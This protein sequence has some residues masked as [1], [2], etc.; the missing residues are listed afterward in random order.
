[1]SIRGGGARVSA[2]PACRSENGSAV[3]EL[4]RRSA[5]A[6]SWSGSRADPTEYKVAARALRPIGE[7][8]SV[9][10]RLSGS[11]LH[12]RLDRRKPIQALTCGRVM[13]E[14][15]GSITG[16]EYDKKARELKERQTEIA[17]RIEQHQKGED[18]YRTT[19][20]TLISLASRAAELFERSK[21][22]EKRELVA[23]VFSNLRLRGKKLEFSLRSPFDLMI[24][25]AD[26]TSWLAFLNTVR[27]ERFD[28]ILAPG[29]LFPKL[30]T[31][32]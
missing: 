11:S 27:T 4:R 17:L 16:D 21:T 25:R 3:S 5:S 31:A 20:E 12:A 1:M 30:A 8:S 18:A 13:R 29:T 23:F 15:L 9:R 10:H 22:E 26:H 32:A 19:L 7:L 14:A 6:A 2:W 28:Q 24:N